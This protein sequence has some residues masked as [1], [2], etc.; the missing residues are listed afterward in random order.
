[1]GKSIPS[2]TKFRPFTQTE[3][4]KIIFI[5]KTSHA[6]WTSE[7][8][9]WQYSTTITSLVTISLR[10]GVFDSR[11]N[12]SIIRPLL[13]KFTLDFISSSYHPVSNLSFLSKL[14]EK[15]AMDHVNEHCNL[16]KLF[17]DYH[18]A[19]HNGYS[20]E[21]AIVK[22]VHDLLWAMENQQV[23]ADM[24]L[25]LLAAFDTVNNE[26]LLRVLKHNFGLEN[27]VLNWFDSYLCPRSCKVSIGKE[28]S[29]EWNLPF[30]VPQESCAGAQIFN[31]YCSKIQEVVNLPLK[32]CGFADD[33]AVKD[34]FKAGHSEDEARC[35]HESEKC[36]VDLKV[37]MDKNQLKMNSDK[38]WVTFFS[39]Q[40]PK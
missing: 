29:S 15:C 31:L 32:L 26:I 7:R 19:Y 18:S 17:P 11:W 8:I 14:L 21:T 16:Y 38:N 25:D 40:N 30:S 33:H 23:T 22:L 5:M 3:V 9:H 10:D 1:M 6:S 24:A 4:R 27:T 39:V 37:W 12:I 34:K 20:C 2:L 36:K 35:I 13:K 28:Y